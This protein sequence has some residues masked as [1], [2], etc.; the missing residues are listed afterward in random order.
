MDTL[1]GVALLLALFA[2][3]VGFALFPLG[4]AVAIVLMRRRAALRERLLWGGGAVLA[5][6]AL[7]ALAAALSALAAVPP[8]T[9]M[10][11]AILA[12]CACALFSPFLVLELFVR[13]F[14]GHPLH[15]VKAAG[16]ER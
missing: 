9:V 14:P 10:A 6:F 8:S 12:V 2:V 16:L 4:V 7:G 15:P 1:F 5:P 11:M 3:L 13:R